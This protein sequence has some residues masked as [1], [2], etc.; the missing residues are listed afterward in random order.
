MATHSSV[1]TWRIPWTEEPGGLCSSRGRK[2]SDVTEVTEH[3]HTHTPNVE[4]NRRALLF[5][6]FYSPSFP[7]LAPF[8]RGGHGNY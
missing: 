5:V 3:T 4:S 2:E 8:L 1:L 7:R 6:H